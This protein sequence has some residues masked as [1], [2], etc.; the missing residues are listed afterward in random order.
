MTLLRLLGRRAPGLVVLDAGDAG[1]VV[2]D[3]LL[4][5]GRTALLGRVEQL[6][7][8]QRV[9]FGPVGRADAQ[10]LH[11]A[12]P[13]VLAALDDLDALLR[14]LRVARRRRRLLAGLIALGLARLAGLLALTLRLRGLARLG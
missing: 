7:L 11:A 6:L 12:R 4:V 9:E 14:S 1:V 3:H 8:H 5:L 13:G 2:L 10:L